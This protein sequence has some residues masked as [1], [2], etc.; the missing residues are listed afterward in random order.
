MEGWEWEVRMYQGEVR[1]KSNYRLTAGRMG[2]GESGKKTEGENPPMIQEMRV[3]IVV[4]VRQTVA[5]SE[6][7]MEEEEGE[8]WK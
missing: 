3:E 6:L 7:V 2:E 1:S 5:G 8:A 4:V